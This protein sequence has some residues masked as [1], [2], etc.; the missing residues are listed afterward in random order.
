[1]AGSVG[2]PLARHTLLYPPQ[3]KGHFLSRVK[4]HIRI[5]SR[6]VAHLIVL[7]VATCLREFCHWLAHLFHNT[8][9]RII[10]NWLRKPSL[11]SRGKMR[12]LSGCRGQS[13]SSEWLPLQSKLYTKRSECPPL[14]TLYAIL[15]FFRFESSYS[16]SPRFPNKPFPSFRT[17]RVIV[18]QERTRHA[19]LARC[20]SRRPNNALVLPD[21][22]SS[23]PSRRPRTLGSHSFTISLLSSARWWQFSGN[24][25]PLLL[26]PATVLLSKIQSL[27]QP[28]H[29]PRLH[30]F[31]SALRYALQYLRNILST[32]EGQH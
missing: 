4:P 24:S 22:I 5:P 17:R 10:P 12:R 19:P 30:F 27:S 23:K 6:L 8:I 21:P 20:H 7:D 28:T 1:L 11:M 14:P 18:D 16:A 32:L 25:S 31:Q 15:T 13:S 29:R 2:R 9:R 3:T 26:R